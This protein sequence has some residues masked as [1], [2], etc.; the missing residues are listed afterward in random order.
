MEKSK[1]VLIVTNAI[2]EDEVTKIQN[3]F[4]T[5]YA[6]N[7]DI[8]LTLVHVIPRL[9]TSYFNIPSIGILF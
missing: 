5:E 6:S 1:Q 7:I 8:K 3:A 2:T 4:S 9:P